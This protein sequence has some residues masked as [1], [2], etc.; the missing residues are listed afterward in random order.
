[1]YVCDFRVKNLC[2]SSMRNGY[3]KTGVK[4]TESKIREQRI[5]KYHRDNRDILYRLYVLQ[6]EKKMSVPVG[7]QLKSIN[8]NTP[9]Q[10]FQ[11]LFCFCLKQF[12][13]SHCLQQCEESTFMFNSWFEKSFPN[14]SVVQFSTIN[15]NVNQ[16]PPNYAKY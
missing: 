9:L 11:I 12:D 1:M 10:G 15:A 7:I 6:T 4:Y 5:K 3:V 8:R 14:F 2:G 13:S 16:K